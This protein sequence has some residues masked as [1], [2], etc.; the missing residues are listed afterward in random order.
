MPPVRPSLS[1][2]APRDIKYDAA[3]AGATHLATVHRAGQQFACTCMRHKTAHTYIAST[4]VNIT[5]A[6]ATTHYSFEYS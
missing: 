6:Y 1:H 2:A 4:T 5:L 3:V